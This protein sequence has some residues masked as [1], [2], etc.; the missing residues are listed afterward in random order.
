MKEDD[1]QIADIVKSING[2]D[3]GKSMLIIGVEENYLLLTDGKS[4]KLEKPKRKNVK[5]VKY[6]AK[7]DTQIAQKLVSGEKITN[8]E[9][10]KYLAS[11]AL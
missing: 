1:L 10:R 7:G 6:L 8:S 4:R 3:S 2:R 5:H 11:R 9:I